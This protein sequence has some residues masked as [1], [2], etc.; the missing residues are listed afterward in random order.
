MTKKLHDQSLER[1][2]CTLI[3]KCFIHSGNIEASQ[4]MRHRV[5][6]SGVTIQSLFPRLAVRRT[7]YL[8]KTIA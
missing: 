3:I 6:P 5:R 1:E 7:V 2:S 8:K 4:I